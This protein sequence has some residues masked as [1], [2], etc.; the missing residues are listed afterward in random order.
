[1]TPE[2]KLKLARRMYTREGF[3]REFVG[4]LGRGLTAAETYYRL[5]QVH[6]D[7]FGVF[8]FPTLNAFHVWRSKR[9]KKNR[10]KI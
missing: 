8:K 9:R 1:M 7:L 6:D 2:D 5:E 10:D 4:R 3:D